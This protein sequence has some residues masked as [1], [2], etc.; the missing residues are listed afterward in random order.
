MGV[1]AVPAVVLVDVQD[2]VGVVPV[3]APVVV[4]DVMIK[5]VDQPVVIVHVVPH[6]TIVVQVVLVGVPGVL[7]KVKY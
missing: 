4:V 2:V 1:L 5:G 7:V 3:D 6:A